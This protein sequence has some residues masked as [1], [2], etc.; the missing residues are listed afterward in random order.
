MYEGEY[1]EEE[2]EYDEDMAED[3]EDNISDDDEELDG[4]GE[5]EGLP[6]EH[7]VDVEDIMEDDD[8][9]DEEPSDEDDEEDSDDMDEEDEDARVEIVDEEGNSRPLG[10]GDEGDEW[11]SEDEDEEDYEGRAADEEEDRDH[12]MGHIARGAIGHLVRALGGDDHEN[13]VE[14]LQRMEDGGIDE[15]QMEL[16]GYLEDG[17]DEDGTPDSLLALLF[18]ACCCVPTWKHKTNLG[19]AEEDDDDDDMDD[20]DGMYDD[21]PGKLN[22]FV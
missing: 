19:C 3:D 9:D 17:Q 12:E 21:Y 13:A 10:E 7:G 6:G 11:Q 22:Q 16:E 15:E 4:M 2:L 8:E 14:I 18:S 5:I 1:D 20:D